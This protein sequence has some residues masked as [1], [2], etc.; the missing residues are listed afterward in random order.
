MQDARQQQAMTGAST[1]ISDPP[2]RELLA[3]AVFV[4]AVCMA[5][6]LLLV[7]SVRA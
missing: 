2:L 6:V 1:G 7:T 5:L 4:G 3:E